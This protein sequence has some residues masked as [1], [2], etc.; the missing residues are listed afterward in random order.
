MMSESWDMPMDWV[1]GK[2]I[3]LRPWPELEGGTMATVPERVAPKRLGASG[4]TGVSLDPQ[5]S[6]C[7][8]WFLRFG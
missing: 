8:T 6:R 7:W 2:K 4:K 1:P 3:R 5:V